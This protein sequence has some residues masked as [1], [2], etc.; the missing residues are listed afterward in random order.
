[1]ANASILQPTATTIYRLYAVF[2]RR[3]LRRYRGQNEISIFAALRLPVE[4]QI[5]AEQDFQTNSNLMAQFS[6]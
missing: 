2:F 3:W 6:V 1:M 4:L 5:E